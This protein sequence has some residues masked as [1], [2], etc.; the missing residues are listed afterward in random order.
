MHYESITRVALELGL[1]TTEN[2]TPEITM[3]SSLSKEVTNN[4]RSIFKRVKAGVYDISSFS[5][6]G[7]E[8][9]KYNDIYCRILELKDALNLHS[10]LIV[11]RRA[12]YLMKRAIECSDDELSVIFSNG[13]KSVRIRIDS[14]DD[15]RSNIKEDCLDAIY[16]DRHRLRIKLGKEFLMSIQYLGL[17]IG[18]VSI[19]MTFD[20]GLSLLE[21]CK[22]LNEKG[23]INIIGTSGKKQLLIGSARRSCE[24]KSSS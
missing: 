10:P 7:Q 16:S 23:F 17:S 13:S 1:I 5:L 12:F 24:Y 18:I 14:I 21:C 11:C 4:P 8:I 22:M 2:K 20:I 15:I 9:I 6:L 19:E 3:S